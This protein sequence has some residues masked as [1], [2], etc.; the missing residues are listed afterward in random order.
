MSQKPEAERDATSREASGLSEDRGRGRSVDRAGPVVDRP[1]GR[2]DEAA[3]RGGA[4]GA[5]GRRDGGADQA[6]T[7]PTEAVLPESL[8]IDAL[9]AVEIVRR[10]HAQDLRAWEAVGTALE[11]VSCVAERVAAALRSGGRLIYV[12]AGT[13]GRL[14]VLDAAECL[15]TFGVGEEGVLAILAGGD[16][17]LRHPVEGAEDEREVG[18]AELLRVCPG[19]QDVVCAIAASGT[20]PF[21]WGALEAASA[22][23]AT[24]VL[25]T[26][27]PGWNAPGREALVDIPVVLPVGPEVLAGST[28]M[29]A[30]TATKCV[31]NMITTT[32]MILWGKVYDNLMVDMRPVND[33]LRGRARRLVSRIAGVT[34]EEAESLL[35]LSGGEVKTAIVAEKAGVEPPEARRILQLSSGKLR[36]ALERSEDGQGVEAEETRSGELG[37]GTGASR[38]A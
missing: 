36:A 29:K 15:P 14:G 17:A 2:R 19:G 23:G 10:I 6:A 32:A 37:G 5:A 7:S 26:C 27:N 33:K 30:G 22:R 35:E 3:D 12:G 28:R 25:V 1:E 18:A 8:G 34:L 38:G 9:E 16:R 11:A 21:V 4:G 24:T 20:T 31:L 13:S